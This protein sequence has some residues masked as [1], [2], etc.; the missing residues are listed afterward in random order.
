VNRTGIAGAKF[1][2]DK[3]DTMQAASCYVP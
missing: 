2:L 3:A 1:R